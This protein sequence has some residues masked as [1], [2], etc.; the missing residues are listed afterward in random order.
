MNYK[1]N[2]EYN[3]EF[4]NVKRIDFGTGRV[5]YVY[6]DDVSLLSVEVNLIP[7]TIL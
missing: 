6:E 3:N 2:N 5:F 7:M 1:V 4:E